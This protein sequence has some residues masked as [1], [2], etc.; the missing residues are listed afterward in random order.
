MADPVAEADLRICAERLRTTLDLF[1]TGVALERARLHREHAGAP[2][3]TIEKMLGAWLCGDI[4][5]EF[6][7]PDLHVR[8]LDA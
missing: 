2:T 5:R 3:D 7:A 4:E 6:A 1:E 8:H